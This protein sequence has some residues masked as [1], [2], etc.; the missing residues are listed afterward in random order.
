M[1]FY[2]KFIFWFTVASLLICILNLS[3][4]DDKNLILF[5]TSPPF[6]ITETHWFVV[7]FTHPA[8]IPL[9][10]IYIITILFWLLLGFI[11]DAIIKNLSKNGNVNS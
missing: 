1:K 2:R 9:D 8:N 7:N 4:Y 11:I 5:F 6:W 10:L 3:G